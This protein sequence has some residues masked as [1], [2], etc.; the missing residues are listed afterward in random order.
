MINRF[1][2]TY[3]RF[4]KP[5]FKQQ[6]NMCDWYC[7]I[8]TINKC[9]ITML[10]YWK[11]IV[12]GEFGAMSGQHVIQQFIFCCE[13][14]QR[15]KCQNCLKIPQKCIKFRSIIPRGR[16]SFCLLLWCLKL[17]HLRTNEGIRIEFIGY[18]FIPY[19]YC[20]LK[21]NPVKFGIRSHTSSSDICVGG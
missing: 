3:W 1:D 19:V 17:S 5:L 21:E 20:A 7:V 11:N 14:Q 4:N 12:M 9:Y 16:K 15:G 10:I 8:Y 6:F 2:M 18:V 13:A